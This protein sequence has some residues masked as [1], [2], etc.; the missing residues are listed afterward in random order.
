MKD[1][2]SL[3]QRL[4]GALARA[5][6]QLLQVCRHTP[7]PPAADAGSLPDAA[8]EELAMKRRRQS[9]SSEMFA[10]LLLELPGY[11]QKISQAYLAG[12]RHGL[13]N[14][15][16]RLRGA[17]AYCD[18]PELELTLRDLHRAI[19]SEEAGTIDACYTR[20]VTAINSTLHYSGCRG[21]AWQGKIPH[22][23]QP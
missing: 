7:E 6:Q 21:N 5:A 1:N 4:T 20:T 12:D 16:H 11:Q 3:R 10:E 18:V 17:V 2:N 9:F 13:R 19:A 23:R 8:A 15:L 22:S 14:H